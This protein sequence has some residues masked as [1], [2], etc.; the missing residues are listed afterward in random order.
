MFIH[1][2]PLGLID[3]GGYLEGP[4]AA[5][6]PGPEG[7]AVTEVIEQR[8]AAVRFPV[9]PGVRL[10]AGDQVGRFHDLVGAVPERPAIAAEMP[11]VEHLTDNAPLDQLV[12]LAMRPHPLQR[13]VDHE[14]PSPRHRRDHGIRFL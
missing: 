7:R 3:G 14:Y 13:P 12:G 2:E 1:F 5:L 9:K 6:V 8:A 11:D 10:L 4:P